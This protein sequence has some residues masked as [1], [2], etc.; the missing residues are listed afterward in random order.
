MKLL[1]HIKTV[2]IYYNCSSFITGRQK[3]KDF[4]NTARHHNNK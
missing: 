3:G 2:S 1:I 4:D